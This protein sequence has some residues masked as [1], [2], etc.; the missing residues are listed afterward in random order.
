MNRR[1]V[2]INRKQ[3]FTLIEML[4]VITVGSLL[5]GLAVL[6]LFSLAKSHSTG[7]EHLEYRRTINSL[8][9]QFRDDV[10][11]SKKTSTENNATTFYPSPDS[12][13]AIKFCYQCLSGR[14]D[15]TELQGEKIVRLESYILPS[16]TEAAIDIQ[17]HDDAVIACI[18]I[19]PIKTTDATASKSN[20]PKLR[21]TTPV[22]IEALLDM[23]SQFTK[24]TA[25]KKKA[26]E[27]KASVENQAA[28]KLKTDQPAAEKQETD[29]SATGE[30]AA[31]QQ[32]AEIPA[33]EIPA[34]EDKP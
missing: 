30:P 20:M 16:G 1:H 17:P 2:L 23:D 22:T 15:R 19:T 10:H 18:I 12:S 26:E 32:K 21:Y 7:R 28:E 27:E 5:T 33:A 9:K 24:V 29:K 3:A 11:A 25:V 14:I 34:K 13:E 8:A 31:E 6:M 4:V